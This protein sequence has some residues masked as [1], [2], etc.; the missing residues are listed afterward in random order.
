M[1]ADI[2]TVVC[3]VAY[4]GRSGAYMSQLVHFKKMS[5]MVFRICEKDDIKE[6]YIWCGTASSEPQSQKETPE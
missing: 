6:G 2:G 5:G 3:I 1:V 4:E